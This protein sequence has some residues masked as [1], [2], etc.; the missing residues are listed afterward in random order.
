[1]TCCVQVEA[2][3]KKF[4][5]LSEEVT[6]FK[7]EHDDLEQKVVSSLASLLFLSVNSFLLVSSRLN[8]WS[9]QL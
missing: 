4:E 3:K 7:Q 9:R 5:E 1:M 6:K 8:Y 2:E